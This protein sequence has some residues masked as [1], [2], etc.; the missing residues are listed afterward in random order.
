MKSITDFAH[1]I[2]TGWMAKMALV[3][4]IGFGASSA[5]AIDLNSA[6]DDLDYVRAF[7]VVENA[8][9]FV[10]D[11]SPIFED[12]MPAYGNPFIT[13][14]YIY[15]YGFLDGRDGVFANGQPAYPE[16]VIG[17]WICRGVM[18][19]EGAKTKTGPWVVSTQYYDFF[20]EP[21]YDPSKFTTSNNLVSEGYE[22]V[23]LNVAYRRAITGGTGKYKKLQGD[24]MQELLGFGKQMN[25]RARFG[26]R[27]K[28]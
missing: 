25:V 9:R 8:S 1:C 18:I 4:S 7:D 27:P 21:G 16:K 6:K 11:E 15:P 10:F 19:G 28:R 5:F 20:D 22:L 26:I 3:I 23:D 12:G 2:K 17:R 24:V 13:E 14:G